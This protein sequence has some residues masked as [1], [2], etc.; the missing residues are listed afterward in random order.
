M[1]NIRYGRTF[2]E[3][4]NHQILNIK[5][6]SIFL[7]SRVFQSDRFKA[8]F[9]DL[10]SFRDQIAFQAGHFVKLIMYDGYGIYIMP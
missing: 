7:L 8:K 3:F 6:R 4:I 1:F 2:L 5:P 10:F 9:P